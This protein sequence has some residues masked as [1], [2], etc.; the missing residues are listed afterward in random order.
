TAAGGAAVPDTPSIERVS[1]ALRGARHAGTA[2]Q[3]VFRQ[4]TEHIREVFWLQDL[5]DDRIVYVSP[6]YETVWGRRA[7]D[8]YADPRVW[9]AAIHPEDRARVRESWERDAVEGRFDQTYRVRR[10]DGS[11]RWIRDRGFPIRSETGEVY[12]VAGLAEDI[13]E[14]RRVEEALRYSGEQLRSIAES[15]VDYIMM[16]DREARIVFINRTVANLTPEQVIGS[17]VYD[18]VEPRFR[19]EMRQCYARVLATGQPDGYTVEYD[20]D[21]TTLTFESRVGPIL[22]DGE[23]YALAVNSRDVTERLDMERKLRD[24][25]VRLERLTDRLHAIREEERTAIAREIHDQLGQMLTGVRLDVSWLQDRLPADD[26]LH[27]RTGHALGLISETL[28][29]VRDL[30]RRLRPASLD[31]FGLEAAVDAYLRD[32]GKVTG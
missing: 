7:E 3:E 30:S 16:L 8:L 23:V 15:A 20:L 2:T 6:T 28:E 31:D 18:W 21:G 27:E 22:R 25:R 13:T 11:V 12:R 14:R 1:E 9:T 26:A 4:L 29:T 32:V 24:A 5:K 19:E 17:S 10:P